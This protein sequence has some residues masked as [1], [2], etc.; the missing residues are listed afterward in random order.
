MNNERALQHLPNQGSGLIV[1]AGI[2]GG[3]VA[4]G[5]NQAARLM[6]ERPQADPSEETRPRKPGVLSEADLELARGALYY[7]GGSVYPQDFEKAAMW[8]RKA[9]DKG[10]VEAQYHLG[11]QYDYGQGVT[12]SH[13][14]AASWYQMAAKQGYAPAQN[15]LG[16]LYELGQGVPKSFPLAEK[17]FRQAA[18]RGLPS[19]QRWLGDNYYH[20]RGVPRDYEQAY[21][22]LYLATTN[23]ERSILDKHAAARDAAAAKLTS[24]EI[25]EQVA[26]AKRWL[27]DHP[28]R[29]Y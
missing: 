7:Y 23:R 2:P 1:R 4:R 20:G 22:W 26:R 5:R 29:E 6:A 27:A 18:D 13:V 8:F 28:P 16:L 3:L 11:H 19:A 21:F 10:V 12:Q 9:A 15:M 25:S 17:W 14:L 24:K